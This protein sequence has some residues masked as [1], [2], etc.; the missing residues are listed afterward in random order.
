MPGSVLGVADPAAT[1]TDAIPSL[2]GGMGVEQ[3]A[4]KPWCVLRRHIMN[5][6]AKKEEIRGQ[7]RPHPEGDF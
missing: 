6:L 1:K 5:G 2:G 7:G 4:N 3:T